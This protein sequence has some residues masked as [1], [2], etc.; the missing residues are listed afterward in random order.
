MMKY[1]FMNDALNRGLLDGAE[2][3]AWFDF[4]FDHGGAVYYDET[5]FAFTWD[6]DWNGKIHIF[7]LKD[8]AKT[9]CITTLQYLPD[10]VQGCMYGVAK[11]MVPIFWQMVREAIESLLMIE[12][13]DDDQEMVLMAYKKYPE[14]FVVHVADWQMG[15]KECG[16]EHMKVR[17][18]EPVQGENK[19]RRA[20]RLAVRRVFPNREDPARRYAACCLEEARRIYGR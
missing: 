7:C 13:L 2:N 4:A 18:K 10:C 9:S 17:K 8:P 16:G 11:S 12:V 1:Y 20:I 5:D 3:I 15:L 14:N 6:Y 19:I